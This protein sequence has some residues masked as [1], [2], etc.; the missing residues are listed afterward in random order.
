MQQEIVKPISEKESRKDIDKLKN[1]ISRLYCIKCAYSGEIKKLDDKKKQSVLRDLRSGRNKDAYAHQVFDELDTSYRHRFHDMDGYFK[2]LADRLNTYMMKVGLEVLDEA[3]KLLVSLEKKYQGDDDSLAPFREHRRAIEEMA[4]SIVNEYKLRLRDEFRDQYLRATSLPERNAVMR[5]MIVTQTRFIERW[6]AWLSNENKYINFERD[7]PKIGFPK[8]DFSRMDLS[9]LDLRRTLLGGCCFYQTDLRGTQCEPSQFLFSREVDEAVLDDEFMADVMLLK[10]DKAIGIRQAL[11]ENILKRQA[12]INSLQ[13]FSRLEY[14][15]EIPDLDDIPEEEL[16]VMMTI[17]MGSSYINTLPHEDEFSL[18]NVI[19]QTIDFSTKTRKELLAIYE[20]VLVARGMKLGEEVLMFVRQQRMALIYENFDEDFNRLDSLESLVNGLPEEYRKESDVFIEEKRKFLRELKSKKEQHTNAYNQD[21][22]NSLIR[23]LHRE[24]DPGLLFSPAERLAR[25]LESARNQDNL[26]VDLSNAELPNALLKEGEVDFSFVHVVL[27]P[28][29]EKALPWKYHAQRYAR[30]MQAV[31][32]EDLQ[33]ITLCCRQGLSVSHFDEA[34]R[35]PFMKACAENRP[36]VVDFML[37]RCDA[38]Q[39]LKSKS[40]NKAAGQWSVLETALAME[41][42]DVAAVLVQ[43][44]AEV[45]FIAAVMLGDISEYSGQVTVK[46]INTAY[47]GGK[48]PLFV[49][50]RRKSVDT[51]EWLLDHGADVRLSEGKKTALKEAILS[52]DLN[53][54]RSI[55]NRGGVI[56]QELIRL[57]CESNFFDIALYLDRE[58]PGNLDLYSALFLKLPPHK[59]DAL[60]QGDCETVQLDGLTS[61]ATACMAGNVEAVRLFLKQGA[62]PYIPSKRHAA[63]GKSEIPLFYAVSAQRA[64]VVEYLVHTE[65]VSPSATTQGSTSPFIEAA[66]NNFTD[67]LLIMLRPNP[68]IKIAIELNAQDAGGRTVLSMAVR[69]GAIGVVRVLLERGA[70]PYLPDAVG[71]TPL[72]Y[73]Y[74][75][76]FLDIAEMLEDAMLHPKNQQKQ[77]PQEIAKKVY[78]PAKPVSTEAVDWE[79]YFEDASVKPVTPKGITQG[80]GYICHEVLDDGECGLTAFGIERAEAYKLIAGKVDEVIFDLLQPAVTDALSNQVFYEFLRAHAIIS[81]DVTFEHVIENIQEYAMQIDIIIA[82][83]EYDLRD[84]QVALGWTHPT[85]LQ[86]LAYI[87]KIPLYMWRL[88]EDQNLIP[89]RHEG[90]YDYAE[91]IPE[92]AAYPRTDLLFSNGNHFNR[93]ELQEVLVASPT[94]QHF[95]SPRA[96]LAPPSP[97]QQEEQQQQPVP[98]KDKGELSPRQDK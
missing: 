40:P 12:W 15:D 4:Y 74:S 86:T 56:T 63:S 22:I 66:K 1:I 8:M 18:L 28:E 50:I 58:A 88:D 23:H 52:G 14:R 98:A 80:K 89:H 31:E 85:V 83:L 24:V 82:Y 92:G 72:H 44:G 65:G 20:R 3:L 54:V 67:M 10:N 76:G 27:T 70:N 47:L 7:F 36:T 87:Q 11:E 93:I 2:S 42:F 45:S 32:C 33:E 55:H 57:A 25:V 46:E 69:N 30:L 53:I 97:R 43:H 73:A 26:V 64:E 95:G 37:K 39:T 79:K 6:E 29:Q 48:L 78:S 5:A 16:R 84:R 13:L 81:P 21:V 62:N 75:E 51:I 34:G 35:T 96:F 60:I 59:I 68:D 90:Y 61:L 77:T 91:F 9:K 49:A 19:E 38:K 71:N 41:H 94:Q 17:L